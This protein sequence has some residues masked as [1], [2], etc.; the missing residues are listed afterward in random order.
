MQRIVVHSKLTEVGE[1]CHVRDTSVIDSAK[2][3]QKIVLEVEGAEVVRRHDMMHASVALFLPLLLLLAVPSPGL[4][5]PQP[6]PLLL[7]L[8]QSSVIASMA[9]SFSPRDRA[10]NAHFDLI[11]N[12]AFRVIFRDGALAPYTTAIAHRGLL[13]DAMIE[14]VTYVYQIYVHMYAF[15]IHTCPLHVQHT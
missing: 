10:R 13:R 15:P 1:T 5:L 12:T 14:C 9:I 2:M 4:L 8:P 6:L 11:P 7:P 3:H